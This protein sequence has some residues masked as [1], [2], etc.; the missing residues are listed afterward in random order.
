MNMGEQKVA[1][2][3]QVLETQGL[4]SQLALHAG[5]HQQ[6]P[7]YL[8]RLTSY[9][10]ALS[11]YD[12]KNK[13]N[14]FHQS[15]AI[16]SM[17]VAK[18]L[19][20][21]RD[22]LALCGWSK[23]TKLDSTRLKTLAEIDGNFKDE[24]IAALLVKV[25]DAIGEMKAGKLTVPNAYKDLTIEI[26]CK[27]DILPDYIKPLLEDLRGLGVTIEEKTDYK[28]SNPKDITEIEFSQQW[29]AEAWLAQQEPDA[30]EVWIN[31]NN[32]RLDNWLHASGRPV[33]G[34]EMSG[35]NPQITQMFL[36]AVQL[37]QRP[38][39]VNTL[40]QYLFLPECPLD[41]KFRRELANRIVSDGGF[42][43]EKVQECV[44]SYIER[45]LKA[46]DDKTPQEKTKDEPKKNYEPYLPFDI[47][48]DEGALPLAEEEDEVDVKKLP[49]FLTSIREYAS[50][51]AVKIAAM[52]PY[53]AR[54]AQLNNVAEMV[55][56]L[57]RQI[58]T[59]VG[60][61]SLTFATLNQWAQSLYEAGD[62]TLYPAQVGSRNVINRPSNMIGEAK[63]TVWCDFYGDVQTTLSTDFLSNLEVE[64]L[65]KAGVLLWDKEH[66][67]EFMLLMLA[68]PIRKTSERLTIIT[69]KQQGATKLPM[70]PLYLQL[71]VK[72][73]HE[74]G[75]ELYRE[76]DSKKVEVI[77]NHSKDDAT[78]IQFGAKEHPVKWRETESY[79]A[80]EKL[81]QNP[82]DYFMK[83]NLGFTDVSDTD[84]KLATTNG[85]VAHDV[86]ESL[87]TTDRGGESLSTFVVNNYEAT[88]SRALVRKGALLLQSEHHL[89]KELLRYKLRQCVIKLATIIEDNKLTVERCEQEET[90]DLGLKD[91]QGGVVRVNGFIDMVLK[92]QAGNVVVF[93]LKWTSKKD[94][95]Q[96]ALEKNRALQ[97]AVYEAMLKKHE[98][99]SGA[100][101]TAYFV[102]PYGVLY[103]TYSFTGDNCV[104]VKPK[105]Q[106]DIME[107]LRN[108]YA[109]R[110]KEISE[111]GI[112][113]ADNELVE[114]LD[115]TKAGNVFPL[116]EKSGK[117]VENKYSDYQC[118]TI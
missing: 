112:E 57:L 35:V 15:I 92:D 47:G 84:I 94:K 36:L 51:R 88:F 111:G 72:P 40:L 7:T 16:D 102:M 22:N 78:E 54:I 29:K 5:I 89:D 10:K 76:M 53:D 3:V 109:E 58:E 14:I 91:G 66:E 45:E 97:L 48:T 110:V 6:I 32:K 96:T 118:F 116:E 62:Y 59:M 95:H 42:C 38:L 63:S 86:V 12:K 71:P 105:K 41:W 65:K 44:N 117:K 1:L 13:K 115:Y 113:T 73:K 90:Q 103:S 19:L 114:N 77:D 4:L 27:L 85:N 98:E 75:D 64:Q 99:H 69:C 107:Q 106:V 34:S 108:G 60:K 24:G 61:G 55:D 67:S 23:D 79:S 68:M 52:R 33:S 82:F 17:S 56:A 26:P 28:E 46:E 70:H 50:E 30:F 18:T 20:R 100:V 31:S 8:E 80:L 2:D 104:S 74:N 101:R 25:R 49:T 83:Y 39:N 43:N 81:L 21:W 87:F 11:D 37:F 93:D 9:H